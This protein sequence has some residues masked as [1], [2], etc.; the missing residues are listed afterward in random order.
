M[1]ALVPAATF[2]WTALQ[3]PVVL[4]GGVVTES[5]AWIPALGIDVSFRIGVLQWVLTLVVSGVGA[6]VLF[7]CR[8]YFAD[9]DPPLRTG[10]VLVAFAGAMTGL[11]TSDDLIGLYVFWELTTV[12]SYLL[13]GHNPRFAANRRAALTALMVTTFG[14]LAMLTGIVLL[15]RP[16]RHASPLAGARGGRGVR[17]R[18][19]AGRHRRSCC[20]WSARCPSRRWSRSTSGC[21]A[22]WPRRPRSAPTCTRPRWSRRASTS[23]RCW[24]RCSP[25][26]R[27]GARSCSTLG[28]ATMIIG[29][30]R[31][32][33]Q[34]D[35]K[36]LLAY[37][38]VSQ[39]GFLVVL[40]GIGTRA[41]A[42][43]GLAL[44]VSHALFKSTL[45]LVVG[46]VDHSAGTRDLRKLVRGRP[47]DAGGRRRRPLLA[48]ASMAA[49]PP[50][51]G[52]AAKEAAFEALTYLVGRRR[53]DRR[54]RCCRRCCWPPRW[55]PARR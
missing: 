29:G 13:V 16:L 4:A 39:L 40:C 27:A 47:A 9:D 45:F 49:V 28:A 12:F 3:G 51:L 34:Y 25:P 35:I 21:P 44:L 46:I 1:L 24:P 53:R 32:L 43:G 50:T 14:G 26:R 18:L 8:C 2:A 48:G 17:R 37:G 19:A 20:C 54:A 33:R 31:A 5:F 11:V 41:A 23:S 38:T 52:F 15:G 7:Y 55:S 10:A 36:V 6:L 30:W 42:L 22:R